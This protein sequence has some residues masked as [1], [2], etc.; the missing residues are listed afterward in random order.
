MTAFF[1]P[2][3]DRILTQTILTETYHVIKYCHLSR[4]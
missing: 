4:W 2:E 3:I 1:L